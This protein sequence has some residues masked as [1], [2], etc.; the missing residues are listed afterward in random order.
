M[1]APLPLIDRLVVRPPNWLGD[2]VLAL[3]AMT[4]VRRA[5]PAAHLAV[6]APPAV[7]ALFR[8][9]TGVEPDEVLELPSEARA[10]EDAL[11]R[12]QF[13]LGVLFPNSFRSAWILRRAGIKERWGVARSARGWLLTRRGPRPRLPAG[14]RHQATYYRAVARGLG[15]A[16]GDE[17][18]VVAVSE[19]SQRAADA[20]LERAGV[21]ASAPL[22][23]LAPGA[24]YG[25]AKQWPPARVAEMAARLVR[26]AG[27]TCVVVGAAHDRETARAI[28]SWLRAEAPDALPRVMDLVGRTSIG[29]LAGIVARTRVFV[30][31]DSGAMHLAAA[32]GRPVV[33]LFGPTDERATRPLG[34][35]DVLT[36]SAFCRPC[37]MRDCPIDHR[38]M[39][40]IPVERAFDAVMRRLTPAGAR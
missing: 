25:E 27:A 15:L 8:E 26:D 28:E 23:G 9:D 21:D 1:S 18:P 36:A 34:D 29:A 24:A 22:V 12:G 3:P 17:D 37:M 4:A 20:L 2:A 32:V 11:A 13:E 39:K 35:H 31:N 7:A 33:A 5:F 19:A 14:D 6:A 40:R 16:C 38:C 30:S 10:I